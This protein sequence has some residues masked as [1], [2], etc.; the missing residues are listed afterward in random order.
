MLIHCP[1]CGFS[2]PKDKYCAQCGVDMESFRP[3]QPSAIKKIL[4][5]PVLQLSFVL[6]LAGGVGLRLYQKE[7]SDL[8]ERVNYLRSG[9]QV[10]R[11]VSSPRPE[12]VAA[13]SVST[14]PAEMSVNDTGGAPPSMGSGDT[15]AS[16]PSG[17]GSTKG[18]VTPE[19]PSQ[20]STP[21]TASTALAVG[22]PTTNYVVRVYY[23]E[24]SSAALQQV[25]AESRNTGQF[26]QLGDHFAGIIPSIEQKVGPSNREIKVLH[27]EVR[28]IDAQRSAQWFIGLK[29]GDPEGEVGFTHYLELTETDGNVFRGNLE[30]VRSWRPGASSTTPPKMSF[31]ALFELNR[32]AG[33]FMSGLMPHQTNLEREEEDQLI[34]IPLFQILRSNA[35][36]ARSTDFAL[37]LEFDRN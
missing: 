18:L 2:Q 36:R 22:R 17:G 32:G 12:E 3:P 33:F 29:A 1:R 30:I 9:V 6:I 24:I 34:S 11:S 25:F 5:N 16:D 35:F 4:T 10:A 15:Y 7:R 19:N 14:P 31:P 20:P 21:S 37:F 28:G 13:A 27:R 26:N 8:Q 23:T